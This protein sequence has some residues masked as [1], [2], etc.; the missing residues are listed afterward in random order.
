MNVGGTGPSV[1]WP[2]AVKPYGPSQLYTTLSWAI[3]LDIVVHTSAD[4]ARWSHPRSPAKARNYCLAAGHNIVARVH[5]CFTRSPLPSTPC[6]VFFTTHNTVLKFTMYNKVMT[7]GLNFIVNTT[8]YR[9]TKR[10]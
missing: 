3:K 10:H 5:V 9:R 7:G 6:V 2:R 4:N 1:A 8:I